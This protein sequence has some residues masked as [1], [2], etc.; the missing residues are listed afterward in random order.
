[1]LTLMSGSLK[2]IQK[3]SNIS[4]KTSYIFIIQVQF[5]FF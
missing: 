4:E 2:Y 1:M 5:P 3:N